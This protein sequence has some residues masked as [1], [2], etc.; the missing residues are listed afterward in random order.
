MKMSRPYVHLW[1]SYHFHINKPLSKS[2]FLNTQSLQF[3]L[4]K[5]KK[6]IVPPEARRVLT[7]ERS[8]QWKSVVRGLEARLQVSI[9]PLHSLYPWPGFK[10][11]VDFSGGVS[12]FSYCFYLV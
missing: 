11:M 1:A 9:S 10:A 12:G 6:S 8:P 2:I 7:A 5:K 3:C 4:K